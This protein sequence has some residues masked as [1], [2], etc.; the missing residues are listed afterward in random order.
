M[1][2]KA[3]TFFGSEDMEASFSKN[4]GSEASRKHLLYIYIYYFFAFIFKT[5]ITNT[6]L[7]VEDMKTCIFLHKSR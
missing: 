1:F 6:K 7:V 3:G 4:L 5:N 2:H